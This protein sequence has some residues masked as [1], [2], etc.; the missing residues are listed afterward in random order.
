MATNTQTQTQL[1]ERLLELIEEAAPIA[2]E[3]G[4]LNA[5][6][7]AYHLASFEGQ[8]HGWMGSGF[9]VDA[10]RVIAEAEEDDDWD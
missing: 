7:R 9:L 2:R 4:E 8:E 1:A 5:A 3:L 10:V 6:F